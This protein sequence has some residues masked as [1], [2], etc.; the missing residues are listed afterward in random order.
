MLHSHL[1]FRLTLLIEIDH[2]NSLA[3][4]PGSINATPETCHHRDLAFKQTHELCGFLSFFPLRAGSP[5]PRLGTAAT[6]VP[7]AFTWPV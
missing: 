2:K 5:Y 7:I 1:A 3:I 6:N 4:N